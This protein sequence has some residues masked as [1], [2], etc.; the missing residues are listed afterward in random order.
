MKRR[1]TM[2]RPGLAERDRPWG[3]GDR[4]PIGISIAHAASTLHR[5]SLTS[6]DIPEDALSVS[7]FGPWAQ[8]SYDKYHR[9]SRTTRPGGRNPRVLGNSAMRQTQYGDLLV[10]LRYATMRM[11]SLGPIRDGEISRGETGAVYSGL[12]TR[13]VRSDGH[14][15]R[16][17]SHGRNKESDPSAVR[18]REEDQL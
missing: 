14:S 5:G 7:E 17:T 16:R 3:E 12:R 1:A 4:V 13:S 9:A 8:D 18:Q 10:Y 6:G 2:Q 15:L 11:A